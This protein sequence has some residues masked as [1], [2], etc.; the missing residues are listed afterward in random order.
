MDISFLDAIRNLFILWFECLE[1][2]YSMVQA[3]FLLQQT[4]ADTVSQSVSLLS[5]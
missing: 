4:N 1:G 3:L 5:H 2:Q